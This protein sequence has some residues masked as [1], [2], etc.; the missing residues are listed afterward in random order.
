MTENL[1]DCPAQHLATLESR[2]PL[3]FHPSWKAAISQNR[4]GRHFCRLG[5]FLPL[6]DG[7]YPEPGPPGIGETGMDV[8]PPLSPGPSRL[9]G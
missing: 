8:A 3:L 4:G 5:G 9:A 1:M 7:F 2:F 6:E